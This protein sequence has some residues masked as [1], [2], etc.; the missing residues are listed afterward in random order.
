MCLQ[1]D[2]HLEAQSTI[3]FRVLQSN[4]DD[5]EDASNE[6]MLVDDEE[7]GNHLSVRTMT[8]LATWS[9]HLQYTESAMNLP[10]M[11]G[12][13]QP[14]GGFRANTSARR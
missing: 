11:A 9:E 14:G 8:G 13:V 2:S 1:R 4:I 10:F 3:A 12:H 5:L 6:L 7:V